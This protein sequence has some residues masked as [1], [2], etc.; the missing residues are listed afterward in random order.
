MSDP[1]KSVQHE[2]DE[3]RKARSVLYTELSTNPV[4]L[5]HLRAHLLEVAVD[6]TM[7]DP[8]EFVVST[9]A[10]GNAFPGYN[11]ASAEDL[12]EEALYSATAESDDEDERDTYLRSLFVA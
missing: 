3:R 5:K 6:G 2:T 4:G 9:L 12:R 1:Q 8:R 11:N 7:D 10:E